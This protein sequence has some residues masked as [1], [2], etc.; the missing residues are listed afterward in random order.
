MK[1]AAHTIRR[2]E[3]CVLSPENIYNNEDL[4]ADDPDYLVSLSYEEGDWAQCLKVE[5]QE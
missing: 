1:A 3:Q 4:I 2:F 5:L